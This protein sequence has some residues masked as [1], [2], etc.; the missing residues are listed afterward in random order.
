MA[1]LRLRRKG[2]PQGLP[3]G[4]LFLLCALRLF[5]GKGFGLK[6]HLRLHLFDLGAFG[7][8][9]IAEPVFQAFPFIDTIAHG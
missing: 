2:E 7:R 8:H 6:L 9:G 5:G 1:A 4:Y 3:L